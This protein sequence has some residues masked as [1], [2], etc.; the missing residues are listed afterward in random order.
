MKKIVKLNDLT[1][2]KKVN[3]KLSNA[4]MRVVSGGWPR[5]LMNAVLSN[6]DPNNPAYWRTW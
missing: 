1:L 4:E 6:I 5:A 2:N 3:A